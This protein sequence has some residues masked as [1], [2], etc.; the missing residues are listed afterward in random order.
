M[1]LVGQISLWQPFADNAINILCL[2]F[3]LFLIS[4]YLNPKT[5]AIDILTTVVIARTPYYILPLFNAD[6]TFIE[7]PRK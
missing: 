2:T 1:H 6:G 5:R 7:L 4:K 3:V